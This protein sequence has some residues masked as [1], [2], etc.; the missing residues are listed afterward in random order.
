M[1]LSYRQS[2]PF[3]VIPWLFSSSIIFLV[4][5]TIAHAHPLESLR[6]LKRFDKNLSLVNPLN[7]NQPLQ[8]LLDIKEVRIGDNALAEAIILAN[9]GGE[10]H[11]ITG[12]TRSD[13]VI[14]SF[15]QPYQESKLEQRIDLYFNKNSGFINQINSHYS[16]TSAYLSI[17][18]IRSL[19]LASAIKKYGQPLTLAQVHQQVGR[20]N[21]DI[22]LSEFISSLDP[23][24]TSAIAY[25]NKLNISR[26]AKL[27]ADNGGFALIHTGF[28]QCYLWPKLDYREILSF[29]A[30]APNAAN[31]AS[32]GLEFTLVNFPV[33]EFIAEQASPT[34]END[35]LTL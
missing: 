8:S 22:N 32:R 30:F 25:F 2:K 15:F 24:A 11:T 6:G 23:S 20:N 19:V 5:G 29:C 10:I 34:I 27:T 7:A 35:Q 13:K 33:A 28:D 17:E 14:F 12:G 1:F 18:P 4:M 3:N 21:G 9:D 16:L 26:Q 31:A